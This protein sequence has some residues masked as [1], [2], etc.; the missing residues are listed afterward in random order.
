MWG[1]RS[2]SNFPF[3]SASLY[4]QN[5]P[6]A[7]SGASKTSLSGGFINSTWNRKGILASLMR[8]PLFEKVY[9]LGPMNCQIRAIL[10][11]SNPSILSLVM[12]LSTLLKARP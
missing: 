5:I 11:A 10:G 6:K 2:R 7:K 9:C 3:P 1:F 4:N 12:A 8:P